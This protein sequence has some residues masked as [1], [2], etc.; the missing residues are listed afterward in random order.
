MEETNTCACGCGTNRKW[1]VGTTL[2]ILVEPT[3][4]GFNAAE[5]NWSVE[6]RYG[7]QDTLYKKYEKEDL[8]ETDD[9]KYIAVVDTREGVVGDVKVWVTAEIPDDD[10]EGG[11]RYE[12]GKSYVCTVEA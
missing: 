8:V 7:S 2:K 11:I 3:A 4:T 1:Y 12:V 6:V 9:G 5:N 10:C